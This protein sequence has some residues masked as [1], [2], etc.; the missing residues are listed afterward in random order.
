MSSA[1]KGLMLY[2]YGKPT[3]HFLALPNFISFLYYIY[4]GISN[5]TIIA[6][7]LVGYEMIIATSALPS[8]IQHT[9]VNE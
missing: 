5:K 6:L 7:D 9:L 2:K 3:R 4:E 1:L 8:R